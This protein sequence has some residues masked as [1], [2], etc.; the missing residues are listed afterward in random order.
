LTFE[1]DL[2]RRAL[3]CQLDA[4]VERPELTAFA[5]DPVA[6]AKANR[7]KLVIAALTILRAYH[8][9]GKPALG[10]TPLGSF[11]AWSSWV[12]GALVWLGAGDPVE[13][14]ESVRARDPRR[15]MLRAVLTA[16][17]LVVGQDEVTARQLIKRANTS[18][19]FTGVSFAN[20]AKDH[21]DANLFDAL[22]AVAG[23]GREINPKRLGR[24]LGCNKDRIV[25]GLRILQV[26]EH[27]GFALWRVEAT[28]TGGSPSEAP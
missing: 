18:A 20:S 21:V 14:M 4:K 13:T 24:W 12:R 16:W 11:E 26:G 9:A 8:V 25:D 15:E 23:Q 17:R 5:F 19:D 3:L 1:G 2:T 10:L 22:L 28:H 27:Q 7:P 6:E